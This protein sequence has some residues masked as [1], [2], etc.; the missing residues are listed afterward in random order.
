MY[1]GHII[2]EALR[3]VLTGC[4]WRNSFLFSLVFGIPVMIVMI[5][6]MVRKSL[7]TCPADD[8]VVTSEMST[9]AVSVTLATE[10]SKNCDNHMIILLPGLSLENLLLFLLCTPCQVRHQW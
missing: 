7:V 8:S 9:A 4:R 1:T 5:S 6:S 10:S 3:H 2:I